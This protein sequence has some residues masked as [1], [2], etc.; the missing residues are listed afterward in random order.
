MALIVAARGII[1]TAAPPSFHPA[2]RIR[3]AS[4]LKLQGSLSCPNRF[5]RAS[6]WSADTESHCFRL[7]GTTRADVLV[8][9]AGMT[10]LLTAA[11]LADSGLDVLV[12][13]AGP[14]GGRN[15]VM[16]TGNLY[17]PVSRLAELVSRWGG[18]TA[19]R[20]VQWRQQRCAPSKRWFIATICAAA[21]NAWPCSTACREHARGDDAIRA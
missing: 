14:I 15:T 7:A 3:E 20:I 8:V 6:L 5:P 11:R 1:C 10:G 18:D 21:S 16:S 13:D 19:S 9:G 2:R 12:V 4:Q 17:A